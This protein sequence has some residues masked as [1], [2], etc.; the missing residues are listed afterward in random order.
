MAS[1]SEVEG[2]SVCC[3]FVSTYSR[4][5]PPRESGGLSKGADNGDNSIYYMS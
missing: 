5:M 3:G 1:G 4:L 2:M